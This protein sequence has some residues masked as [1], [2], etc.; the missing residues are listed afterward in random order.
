MKPLVS[1]FTCLSLLAGAALPILLDQ[2]QALAETV[3][4]KNGTRVEGKIVKEDADTFTVETRDG[5]RKLSKKDIETLPK[6]EPF[7]A[8]MTGLLLPGGGQLYTR[9]LDKAAMYLGLSVVSGAIGWFAASQIRYNSPSTNAVTALV[10][11]E[12]PTVIG[13]FDAAG[14]AEQIRSQTRY[15]IDYEK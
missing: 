9:Q 11:L 15:H 12:I 4:M 2:R 7:I 6:P 5:R 3:Y 10:M 1:L 14:S 13:A 8:L